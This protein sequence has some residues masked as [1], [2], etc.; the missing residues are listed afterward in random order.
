MSGFVPE[1]FMFAHPWVLL[2]LLLL[3]ILALLKGRFGGTPGVT[4]SSTAALAA[5]GRRRRSRAGAWLSLLAHLALA[6]LIIALARP[7]LGR[8]LTKVQASGVDIMLV[9]D[10]SGSMLAEDFSIGNQRASRLEAVKQVTE[11][12]IRQRPNDRIGIV[13]FSGR[14]YLVSPMTLDHDWLIANLERLRVGMVEDGTAIGSALATAANRLK[15]KDAKTKLVVLL[16]DGENN[17]GR[18][19]P[20]TAAE[21]AKAL[22]IRVYTIGAG[23]QEERVPFPRI[24]QFG[25]TRGY[26]MV[27]MKFNEKTL[28][29]IASTTKGQYFP[30]TDTASLKKTFN[31]IDQMEKTKI[32]VE[33]TAD[34]RDLFPW[35]LVAGFIL[36]GAEVLLSQTIWKRLP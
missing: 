22:G 34:Y 13:A 8:T 26:E 4:F 25:R 10:V 36:L 14:P 30:A 7:Q 9:L 3:P 27:E 20:M 29:D 23:S 19:D 17:R 6:A 32:E 15:D 28:Q 16:S 35:F 2:L 1:E 5:L 12:F 33:K 21:A 11:Q 24:D 31:E 18:I